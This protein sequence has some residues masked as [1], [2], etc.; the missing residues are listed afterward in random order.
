M[1]HADQSEVF[2]ESEGDRWFERN[3]VHLEECDVARDLPLRMMELYQIKPESVLEVGAS[4][5]CRL[6]AIGQ[7]YSARTVAVE[8]SMAAIRDGRQRFESVRFVRATADRIDLDETFDLIIVHFVLHWVDR[9]RLFQTFAELDRLLADGGHLII[10]DFDPDRPLRVGYHHLPDGQVF[11]YKQNYAASF[12]ASGLYRQVGVLSADHADQRLVAD[13]TS[14]ERIAVWL[15]QKRSAG[16]HET[17]D[18]SPS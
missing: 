15:L 5:G 12:L 13:V 16:F 1:R 2:A 3:C 4:N 14:N 6:A 9:S 10:G 11:T 7:R 18:F 8:P 17:T